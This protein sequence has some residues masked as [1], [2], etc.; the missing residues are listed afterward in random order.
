MDRVVEER[1]LDGEIGRAGLPW[2]LTIIVAH[3]E[4]A[5]T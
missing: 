4:G 2:R 5:L 3:F 1:A